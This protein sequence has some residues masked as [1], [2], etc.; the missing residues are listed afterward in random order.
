MIGRKIQ[1][2]PMSFAR[3]ASKPPANDSC[4]WFK[5]C[6][7]MEG[8]L[9]FSVDIDVA[10]LDQTISVF[11]SPAHPEVGSEHHFC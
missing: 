9:D 3:P 11:Y 8:L 5:Y 2:E 10:L 1:M 4:S 6:E 7:N